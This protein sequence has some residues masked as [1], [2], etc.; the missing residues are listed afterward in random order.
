[1]YALSV[2]NEKGEA[3][4]LT[5]SEKYDVVEITGLTTPAAAVNV[6]EIASV[7]GATFIGSRVGTRNIV[8]TLNI[9]P[10]VEENRIA[11]YRYFRAK[12][13]VKIR[14]KNDHRE[15]FTEGYVESF[16]NNLFGMVQQP[17]IS[18]ICPDPFW[19]DVVD[20]K[21]VFSD[22]TA[23]FEFPFSIA[24]EGVEF[25]RIERMTST[26]INIG[27]VASG[28]VI[29]LHAAAE[30]VNPTFYNSTTNEF[31][32]LTVT[33]QAGDIII[34][35]TNAGYKSVTLTRSGTVTNLISSRQNGSKWVQFE[36]G[37]N[38]LSYDASEGQAYLDVT[39]TA[40]QK[41]EGV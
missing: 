22:L 28:A 6:S 10:P 23:L 34:I 3:L 17:Q 7:D 36:P 5:G 1:M 11:L 16:E 29:R 13:Y 39:V 30:V 4:T 18:V 31:L 40:V 41:F 27:E 8:I 35:N 19:R 32:G 21:A 37:T 2:E 20:T 9:K 33:M 15:V 12:R 14:Y 26:Y 25:S 24:A 38:Q